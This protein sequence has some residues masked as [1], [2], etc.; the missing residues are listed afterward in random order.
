MVS[1]SNPPPT[2]VRVIYGHQN[3]R[4]ALVQ[5]DNPTKLGAL[6]QDGY[7][8][9]AQALREVAA[10]PE[11]VVTVLTGTGRFFS[12]YVGSFLPRGTLPR[13]SSPKLIGPVYQRRRRDYGAPVTG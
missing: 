7:F 8:E 9:L 12:A 4:V 13:V 11:V 5:I 10:R 1:P 2:V 6:D 3:G